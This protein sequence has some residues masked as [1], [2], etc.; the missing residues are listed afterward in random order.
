MRCV[1]WPRQRIERKPASLNCAL[2]DLVRALETKVD[3]MSK[4]LDD[5]KAGVA[6]VVV[7]VADAVKALRDLA[8][9]VTKP[10]QPLDDPADLEAV[11]MQL[12]GI[13]AGLEAAIPV[14]SV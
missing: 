8:A 2:A 13:A 6:A 7:A 12:N 10:P 1:F 3:R 4:E 9:Q 11:A 5:V 14:P